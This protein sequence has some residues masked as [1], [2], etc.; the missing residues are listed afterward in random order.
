M[1]THAAPGAGSAPER[2][3]APE[4]AKPVGAGAEQRMPPPPRW[5]APALARWLSRARAPLHVRVAED[6]LYVRCIGDCG[7]GRPMR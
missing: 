7:A 4:S 3:P 2:R 1:A 5:V 6:E